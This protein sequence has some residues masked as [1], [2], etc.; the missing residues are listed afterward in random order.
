MKYERTTWSRSLQT[1]RLGQ[2]D[3]PDKIDESLEDVVHHRASVDLADGANVFAMNED[4]AQITAEAGTEDEDDMTPVVA[5]STPEI[6]S[7]LARRWV[8]SMSTHTGAYVFKIDELSD[9]KTY[10]LP[11]DPLTRYKVDR[12]LSKHWAVLDA[13]KGANSAYADYIRARADAELDDRLH[14]PM[15]SWLGCHKN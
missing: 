13:E 9:F 6:G 14:C 2:V 11:A 10:M 1:A 8:L 12:H 3:Q 15:T 5:Q 7:Q 4:T